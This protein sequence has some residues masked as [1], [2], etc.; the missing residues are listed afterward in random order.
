[1]SC[2]RVLSSGIVSNY[3]SIIYTAMEKRCYTS[4]VTIKCKQFR[5]PIAPKLIY[6][7]R[8]ATYDNEA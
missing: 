4:T 7:F 3:L 5:N 1:M 6:G 8:V 2:G